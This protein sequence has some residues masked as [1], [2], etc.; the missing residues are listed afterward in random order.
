[1]TTVWRPRRS[2][3]FPPAPPHL[4]HL[5]WEILS[6]RG[7]ESGDDVQKWLNPSLKILRDPFTLSDL[8][9]AVRRLVQARLRQEA[10][11]I[12]A[13]YDLDGTSGLALLLKAFERMGFKD[14][15]YYQPKRL[16]EGYG[17]HCEAVRSFTTKGDVFS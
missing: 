6:A 2:E 1:M 17:L 4:P 14:V 13:D 7:I 15:T 3:S 11:V 12:Y 16:S 5:I 10:I 9:K 8:D